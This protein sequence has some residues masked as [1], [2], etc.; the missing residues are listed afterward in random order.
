MPILLQTALTS[1]VSAG[2]WIGANWLIQHKIWS[3]SEAKVYVS[4]AAVALVVGAWDYFQKH[5][6]AVR[7]NTALALPSGSTVQ[8]VKAEIKAGNAPPA[9]VP[10]DR[11][12]Y[13]KGAKPERYSTDPLPPA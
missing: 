4:A 5:K 12:P 2:L 7:V 13:L 8:D 6:S 10:E 1:I 11:A 9:S 3:E